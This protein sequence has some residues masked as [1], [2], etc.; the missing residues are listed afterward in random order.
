M[1]TSQTAQLIADRG[2]LV[3]SGPRALPRITEARAQ[4]APGLLG[5]Y[6]TL[7]AAVTA[8]TYANAFF[9]VSLGPRHGSSRS[10]F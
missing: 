9:V 5:I 3:G 6:Q 1:N 10:R 2:L 7:R 4:G 8:E